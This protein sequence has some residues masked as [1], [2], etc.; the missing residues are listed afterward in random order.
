[1]SNAV[2]YSYGDSDTYSTAEG[3]TYIE[4]EQQ[5]TLYG[6]EIKKNMSGY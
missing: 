5:N 1:M 3:V 6:Q 4:G 2:D